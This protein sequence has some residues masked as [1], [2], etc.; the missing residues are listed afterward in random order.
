MNTNQASNDFDQSNNTKTKQPKGAV[1]LVAWVILFLFGFIFF[2]MVFEK[3]TGTTLGAFN[4]QDA[5]AKQ[6]LLRLIPLIAVSYVVYGSFKFFL[7]EFAVKNIYTSIISFC[8]I[9]FVELLLYDNSSRIGLVFGSL[10]YAVATFFWFLIDVILMIRSSGKFPWNFLSQEMKNSWWHRLVMVTLYASTV[11]FSVFLIVMAI[12]SSVWSPVYHEV[13]N[14]ES[15]FSKNDGEARP[16]YAKKA[17]RKPNILLP[18]TQEWYID[19]GSGPYFGSDSK[20]IYRRYLNVIGERPRLS[21]TS[22]EAGQYLVDNGIV[23]N[24]FQKTFITYNFAEQVG[25]I[26]V[27][28]VFPLLWFLLLY[29]VIYR[30]VIYIIFGSIGKKQGSA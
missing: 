3:L 11:G 18:T 28:F 21:I 24:L 23:N 27:L 1:V 15:S 16:C 29:Q 30:V 19:C 12:R 17:D 13:Y 10:P 14:F 20:E 22:E 2:M 4:N 5:F 9:F 8:V 26:I 25:Q 6:L 7:T